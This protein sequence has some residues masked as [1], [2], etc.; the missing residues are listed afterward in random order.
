MCCENTIIW[1][2]I[3]EPT[4]QDFDV[5]EANY[6]MHCDGGSRANSCAAAG[7]FLEA[8]VIRGQHKYT[9]P[10]GMCGVLSTQFRLFWPKQSHWIRPSR[11]WHVYS[12]GIAGLVAAFPNRFG[13]HVSNMFTHGEKAGLVA[14]FPFST[15]DGLVQRRFRTAKKLYTTA[16]K[17]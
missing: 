12:W 5:A 9:F 2:Q 4:L 16:V 11:T 17:H 10:I 6:I 13:H 7:W 1:K 8:I 14:A 3:W 15:Y